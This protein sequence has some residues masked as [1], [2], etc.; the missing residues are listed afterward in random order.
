[1]ISGWK[2]ARHSSNLGAA[3]V[4]GL[5]ATAGCARQSVFAKREK[6]FTFALAAAN[7]LYIV[8][9]DS[10]YADGRHIRFIN[11]TDIPKDFSQPSCVCKLQTAVGE[12]KSRSGDLNEQ[13]RCVTRV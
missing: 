5:V 1:M 10:C 12:T 4:K 11:G 9:A 6:K 2:K 13:R 3:M 7:G 8:F